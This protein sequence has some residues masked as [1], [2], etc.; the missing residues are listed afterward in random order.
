MTFVPNIKQFLPVIPE[1]SPSQKKSGSLIYYK[2]GLAEKL[3][4]TDNRVKSFTT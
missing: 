1:I 4:E 3:A 2:M